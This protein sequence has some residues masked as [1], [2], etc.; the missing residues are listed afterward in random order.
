MEV[1]GR[2]N[3]LSGGVPYF[4]WR[5]LVLR[6]PEKHYEPIKLNHKSKLLYVS[7]TRNMLANQYDK[8]LHFYNQR[9][10]PAIFIELRWRVFLSEEDVPDMTS[11]DITIQNYV[12]SSID[13]NLLIVLLSENMPTYHYVKQLSFYKGKAFL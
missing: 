2:G 9:W 5:A 10:A 6:K 11:G 8:Q 13:E 7:L 12:K 3:P 4:K 1:L